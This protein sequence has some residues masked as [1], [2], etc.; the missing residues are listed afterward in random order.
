MWV[1]IHIKY[2]RMSVLKDGKE[3]KLKRGDA[4]KNEVPDEIYIMLRCDD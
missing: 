4:F 2:A 1:Y 3:K